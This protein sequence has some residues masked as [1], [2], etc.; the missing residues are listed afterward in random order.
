M[1]LRVPRTSET[2]PAGAAAGAAPLAVGSL[3]TPLLVGVALSDL[4]HGLPIDAQQ[5]F[6][7]G[8]CDLLSV[9]SV[10]G[11]LTFVLICL[12]HG[13]TFLAL[14]TTG[15]IRERAMRGGPAGS[16]RSPRWR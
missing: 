5:E 3:L 7:G 9:Y 15:D 14:K 11:G 10:L 16:R 13:A 6:V 8:F 2:A 4:L 12:L 1:T